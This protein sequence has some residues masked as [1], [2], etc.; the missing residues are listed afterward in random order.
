M[1]KSAQ[2]LQQRLQ[3][4]NITQLSATLH[5]SAAVAWQQNI[6][7]AHVTMPAAVMSE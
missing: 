2:R 7:S 4:H 3:K 6:R 1:S 5:V